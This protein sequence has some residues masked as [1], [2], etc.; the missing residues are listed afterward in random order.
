MIEIV[1]TD[2]KFH[3]ETYIDGELVESEEIS[4]EEYENAEGTN[5]CTPYYSSYVETSYKK[6]VG[7]SVLFPN[8]VKQ[9]SML[10]TLTWKQPPKYRSYDVFAFR[11]K[12]M[13]YSGYS[14]SQVYYKGSDSYRIDYDSSSPGYKALSNGIGVSM[15]LKDDNDITGYDMTIVSKVIPDTSVMVI[16]MYLINMHKQMFLEPNL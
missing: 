8:G 4:E 10:G 7:A 9:Y 13:T 5:S 1:G 11:V 3:K 12:N 15:N 16:Y 14:A 6:L 2:S